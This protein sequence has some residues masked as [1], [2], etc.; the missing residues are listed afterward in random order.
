MFIKLETSFILLVLFLL[1]SMSYGASLSNSDA[2]GTGGVNF[3][4]ETADREN[5]TSFIKVTSYLASNFWQK[6]SSEVEN[7]WQKTVA[8]AKII[9]NETVNNYEKMS[10]GTQNS[11]L[12]NEKDTSRQTKIL[13]I[14]SVHTN[15]STARN[16]FT[17][18]FQQQESLSPTN[19]TAHPVVSEY[20][21]KTFDCMVC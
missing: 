20:Q 21:C 9:A 3:P 8:Y 6:V 1:F 11:I 12:P 19:S 15:H 2:T 17:R 4:R 16:P 10:S 7:G 14:T 5:G 13:P 18:K